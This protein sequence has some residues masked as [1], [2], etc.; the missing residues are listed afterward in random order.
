MFLNSSSIKSS[1]KIWFFCLSE[2]RNLLDMEEMN[3]FREII[4]KLVSGKKYILINYKSDIGE[5]LGITAIISKVDQ[6][7]IT[8]NT[9][10]IIL[11]TDLV[12]VDENPAP[13]Y[14]VNDYRCGC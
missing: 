8:L 13:G 3:L 10:E 4:N 12:R 14:N 2:K 7:E 9:G 5:Y 11:L 1:T 6:Y